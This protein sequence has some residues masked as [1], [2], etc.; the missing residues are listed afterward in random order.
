[1]ADFPLR[2]RLVL[3]D[4]SER[5]IE[6]RQEGESTWR[7]YLAGTEDG[8]TW[9]STPQGA[10]AIAL[11]DYAVVE[12]VPEGQPLRSELVAALRALTEAL[13]WCEAYGACGKPAVSVVEGTRFCE[14]CVGDPDGGTEYPYAAP[15]RVA[16]ALLARCL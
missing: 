14:E 8:Y 13:P 5:L 16:L 7:A 1:M 4:G 6:L 11:M 12:A 9:S 3:L 10:L 2:W 15:L